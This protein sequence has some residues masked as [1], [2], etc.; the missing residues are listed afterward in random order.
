[1]L[2]RYTL[3]VAADSVGHVCAHYFNV[4]DN[5][6][7]KA[8]YGDVFCNPPW[9]EIGT[10]VRKA[11]REW[12]REGVDPPPPRSISMLLPGNRQEQPWWQEMIEPCRDLRQSS[13]RTFYPAKRQVFGNPQNPTGKGMSA[14]P[15]PVV[16][17]VWRNQW[18]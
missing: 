4:F 3:D 13:L 1:M 14:L 8:W 2:S 7:E 11:W 12:R 10:W 18:L 16:L 6:L 15:Y 5:G 9:T 17:C